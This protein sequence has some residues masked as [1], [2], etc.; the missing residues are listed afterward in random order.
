MTMPR[1]AQ[2]VLYISHNGL[3]EPLGRRQVLP[4]VVGLAA[5]GWHMTVLSFEKAETATPE[6]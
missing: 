5:R 3:T 1:V 6:A 2:N 4:Y